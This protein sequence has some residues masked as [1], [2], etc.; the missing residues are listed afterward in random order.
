MMF[1]HQFCFN[2]EE[3]ECCSLENTVGGE[4]KKYVIKENHLEM[5]YFAF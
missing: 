4:A 1:Q 2:K 5:F 3:I